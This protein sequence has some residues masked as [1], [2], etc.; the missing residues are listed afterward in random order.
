[1]ENPLTQSEIDA[2]MRSLLPTE[3]EDLFQARDHTVRA[4]DFRRPTKFK[5]DL[6]R[7]LVMIH[8]TFA[9]L[10]QSFFLASLRT[11]AQ[12]S[13]RGANQY[14][15][16]EYLELLPTPGVVAKFR[17]DPLPGTCLMEISM[18]IAFAIIDRVFGGQG[19]DVQPQRELSEIEQS[20]MSRVVTE[21]FAPL[22][23]AWRNVASVQPKLEGLESNSVFLQTSAS[24]TEVVAAI[25]LAVEIGEHLGHI[26]LSFP[27]AA[28]EPVLSRL[29]GRGWL[30]DAEL[31]REGNSRLLQES[32]ALAPVP[33]RV[34]LGRTT[35][36]VKEFTEL[37]VGDIIPLATKV[38]GQ[39][40]VYVGSRRAF[41]GS[42]GTLNGHLAVL[43]QR[44]VG[45]QKAP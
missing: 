44:A 45:G 2:L 24:S 19:A 43:I 17:M 41:I 26:T 23:E 8:D 6:M 32:V 11:P 12:V 29:T 22:A 16:A 28:V 7:A 40:S 31:P 1:L 13:V 27:H 21:M 18:N 4:Y 14:T 10:L 36:T 42:P 37:Q 30:V 15:Y 38:N 35:I 5:K 3:G 25:T 34:E 9:R 39:V 33:V 20:V